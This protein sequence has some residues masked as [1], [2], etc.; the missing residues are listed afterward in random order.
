MLREVVEGPA[1]SRAE[2]P[3]QAAVLHAI[4]A[5]M[6]LRPFSPIQ[7]AGNGS[8]T[9]P[10]IRCLGTHKHETPPPAHRLPVVYTWTG[11]DGDVAIG[12]GW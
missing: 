2:T 1:A 11:S 10:V 12:V 4:H 7:Y 9:A 5:P 3:R 8:F 6:A